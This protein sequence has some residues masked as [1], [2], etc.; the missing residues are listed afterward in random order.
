MLNPGRAHTVYISVLNAD[1]KSSGLA[2]PD[3]DTESHVFAGSTT[4]NT[5][6]KTIV[7]LFLF[8]FNANILTRFL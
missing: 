2:D 4:F 5:V 8:A 1:P 3:S 7:E 6:F